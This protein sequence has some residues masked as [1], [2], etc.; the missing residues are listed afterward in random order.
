[1]EELVMVMVRLED[2]HQHLL[3]ILELKE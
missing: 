1:V 3:I 2:I